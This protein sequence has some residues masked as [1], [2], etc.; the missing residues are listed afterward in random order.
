MRSGIGALGLPAHRRFVFAHHDFLPSRGVATLVR[1]VARR[2]GLVTVP[3]R[4]VRADLDPSGAMAE[5]IRVIAP[6]VDPDR[7]AGIGPPSTEPSVL[8]LGALAPWKRPDLG[9]EVAR[10][11]Q[12]E[13]AGLTLTIVGAPVADDEPFVEWLYARAADP[14]LA[15]TVVLRGPVTDPRGELEAAGCLLHCAPAEPF[16][17]AILEALAAGRPVVAP[18]AGGPREIIDATCGELYPPGDAHAAARAVIRVL[19]DPDGARTM[20]DAGRARVRDRFTVERCRAEFSDALA[21]G[22]PRPGVERAGQAPDLTLVTVSHNSAQELA[23]LIRSRDTHLPGTPMI[24]VDC[25]SRDASVSV[26]G[27]RADITV[28]AL[29]ENLGFG[30]ACNL[31]LREVRSPTVALLNPDVE[32]LDRSLLDVAAEA[33]RDGG[34]DRLLAPLV[35][36]LDGTRQE[37][38]HPVPTSAPEVIRAVIPPALIPTPALAPWRAR[39]PR[40]VGWAVGAAL[41]ARTAVLRRLGPFDET[42]FMYGEDMELGLRAGRAGV[43]TWFWPSA[44][45]LHAGA[46]STDRTFGGEAFHRLAEARDAALATALGRR[47]ARLD[48]RLQTVTF[49]SRILYKAALGR[50]AGRERRQLA[51]VRALGSVPPARPWRT[52]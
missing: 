30:R 21:S 39:H 15:G 2:A 28:I 8:V 9:L 41:V 19:S 31:G 33:A 52:R 25:A 18:D 40:R 20:G 10:L 12:R 50:P 46:H 38:V 49:A 3:S 16:G 36:N 37:T 43:A 17:V 14:E 26:A 27:G 32:L 1:R 47:R 44:R 29:D 42:I 35:L 24:V 6:G 5:H 7:F 11:A 4:A 51:A 45:V 23:A 13:L 34:A 22:R 48:R